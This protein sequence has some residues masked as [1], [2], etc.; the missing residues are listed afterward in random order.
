MT[1]EVT[2]QNMLITKTAALMTI[3]VRQQD[4]LITKLLY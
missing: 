1:I 4:M 2:Q 3:E